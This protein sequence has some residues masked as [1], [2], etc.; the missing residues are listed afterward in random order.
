MNRITGILAVVLVAMLTM[1][2]K[3]WR[4][5][6][7]LN[8]EVAEAQRRVADLRSSLVA[9]SMAGQLPATEPAA[10]AA[11]GSMAAA[12]APA[13]AA[14]GRPDGETAMSSMMSAVG[15]MYET[16]EGRAML[17]AQLRANFP[18]MYPGLAGELGLSP[19]AEEKFFDMLARQQAATAA[20]SLNA[21]NAASGDR[22]ANQERARQMEER[23]RADEAELASMLG[24][25]LPQW[26]A[27]QKSLPDRRQL[28]QLQTALG[29]NALSESQ[30]KS[31]LAS[32]AEERIR[33]EQDRRSR[34]IAPAT[35]AR[36]AAEANLQR[37][38]DENR[39]LLNAASVHLNP[40]QVAG[41]EQM[42]QQQAEMAGVLMRSMV[43]Q[44]AGSQAAPR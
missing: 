4:D 26:Q 10:V 15:A 33:I 39:R 40:A 25:K 21:G 44:S 31:V 20:V 18:R 9:T 17:Q 41:Y 30:T 14:S 23:R 19:A 5:L 34:R 2:G 37:E 3:S 36:E 8:A 22:A 24:D 29:R 1:A 7:E 12:T 35:N 11:A 13:A 32:L 42:L 16:E 28:D 27:Y 6:R 38:L 43:P